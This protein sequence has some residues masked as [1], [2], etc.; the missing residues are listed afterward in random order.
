MKSLLTKTDF[1]NAFICPTKL[2]YI[3]FPE[4]YTDSSEEDEYLQSL[5]DGGYQVG[6]LA[7]LQ[8]QDGI[9][10]SYNNEEAIIETNKLI[11]QDQAIIFEAAIDHANFFIR[12]DIV[13]KDND[14]IH[15]IEVKAKSYDSSLFEEDNFYNQNGSIKAEWQEYFYDLAFQYYVT[16]SKYPNKK[17][18]CFFHLPNKNITSK[19]DNLFNKF[20]IKGKKAFFLGTK[21][22]LID[23]LIYEAEVTNK[24]EEIINSTFEFNHQEVL[25]T[26]I[27]NELAEAKINA[28]QY[29]PFIGSYCKD[30]KFRDKDKQKS[31]MHECWKQLKRFTDEK[32]NSDKVIDIWNIRSTKKL[33]ERDKFFIDDLEPSDLN[34]ESEP[35]LS[36]K[37]FSNQDRQYFQCFG[38]DTFKNSEGYIFNDHFLKPEIDKWRYPLNFIDFETATLAIPPYKGLSPYEMVAFQY[39][40][41]TLNENGEIKHSSQF[42]STSAKEFPNFEFIKQLVKDLS[43]NEGSIF[44]WYPHEQRTIEA[45]KKQILKLKLTEKYKDELEFIDRLLPMGDRELIDLYALAKNG[46][47]YP[48]SKGSV[49]IKKVLPAVFHHSKFIQNKYS[50][51]I[52]GK[53]NAIKSLNFED[54]AWVQKNNIG[55]KDPYEIISEIDSESINQGGMAATTFAKLQFSDLNADDRNNLQNALLRYCELDTF[56]MVVIAESWLSHLR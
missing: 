17:I 44:M 16:K 37:P 48:N 42:L 11:N 25:F 34:I 22:D 14:Q 47:F 18:R 51:P 50:K 40:I 5:S 7:Q 12:M 26:D 2:N 41:H 27:S 21:D 8:F 10:V 56:A 45:I 30:C 23:N 53:N 13:K 6:K 4:K 3:R 20:S 35:H 15:L 43:S 52:Y 24:I 39:S 28:H 38:I 9:E 36:D 32:F 33:L 31:G 29:P 49:S 46:T 54:V 55:F 1:V 19:V